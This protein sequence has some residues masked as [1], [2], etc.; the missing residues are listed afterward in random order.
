[1]QFLRNFAIWRTSILN[2]NRFSLAAIFLFVGLFLMPGFARVPHETDGSVISVSGECSV[3]ILGKLD[4]SQV[5]ETYKSS[6]IDAGPNQKDLV[7]IV[8]K[9][10]PPFVCKS[11]NKIAFYDKKHVDPKTKS[12]TNAP[13]WVSDKY[14][15]LINVVAY[16]SNDRRDT[17]YLFF[18]SERT[19][20]GSRWLE[21]QEVLEKDNPEMGERERRKLAIESVLKSWPK[22][23]RRII[24]EA[25]HCAS[26]LIDKVQPRI[27]RGAQ[28]ESWDLGALD[29]AKRMSEKVKPTL[30]I[31]G[32]FESMN[33]RFAQADWSAKYNIG[34]EDSAIGGS[35]ARG[36]IS[37]YGQKDAFEDVAELGSWVTFIAYENEVTLDQMNNL[38]FTEQELAYYPNL[39]VKFDYTTACGES[40]QSYR[41]G[42]ISPQIGALYVKLLFL[43]DL[44]FITQNDL[45][46]CLGNGEISL[47]RSGSG[48]GFQLFVGD[49]PAF[50]KNFDQNLTFSRLTHRIDL[51]ARG[52][53]TTWD[54]DEVSGTYRLHIEI[55]EDRFPRGMYVI[56]SCAPGPFSRASFFVSLPDDPD[57][58]CT[59]LGLVL[60][61]RANSERIEGAISVQSVLTN[62]AAVITPV[63]S[64]LSLLNLAIPKNTSESTVFTF[65][66]KQN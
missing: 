61:T 16:S 30:G 42:G 21:V 10:L 62:W 48:E 41:G 6:L 17:S 53:T 46:K 18:A 58:M 25:Y 55:P 23:A 66:F 5:P 7:R 38:A 4:G 2:S 26:Y 57:Y 39:T 36:F 11:V 47:R 8:L 54:G 14:P 34:V 52:A 64:V 29:H 51:S 22:I 32:E 60:I 24:H 28:I 50:E 27:S 9:A 56:E 37:H 40:L 65:V 1:M 15:D 63:P 35:I 20:S 12:E 33:G 45:D 19:L 44:E 31:E 13:A 43:L 3:R 59:R 49:P